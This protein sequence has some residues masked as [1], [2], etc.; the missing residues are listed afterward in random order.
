MSFYPY[1]SQTAES[2]KR[3][4]E[5]G[6]RRQELLEIRMKSLVDRTMKPPS[7]EILTDEVDEYVLIAATHENLVLSQM[8]KAVESGDS[9]TF[10]K[11][12]KRFL[13]FIDLETSDALSKK[14]SLG[15][16]LGHAWFL[17]NNPW[18]S[19]QFLNIDL[20]EIKEYR[21]NNWRAYNQLCT[22]MNERDKK[23]CQGH[24]SSFI[25]IPI[26]FEASRGN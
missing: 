7:L 26:P 1:T 25:F 24:F 4:L 16:K 11:N 12:Q 9:A 19:F 21:R 20:V 18:F 22:Q 6:T 8:Q 13:E 10:W 14:A 15:Y 2:Q 3:H 23:Y 17:N 5:I